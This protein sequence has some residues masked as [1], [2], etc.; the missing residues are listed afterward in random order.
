MKRGELYELQVAETGAEALE[1][2]GQWRPDVLVL[3]A[4]LPDTTG[5][6]L[7]E[8]GRTN[9]TIVADVREV[10]ARSGSI[11]AFFAEV[12]QGIPEVARKLVGLAQ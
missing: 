7:L 5:L 6:A 11:E 4:N 3:D 9:V 12:I 8:D 10:E 1:L 2:A